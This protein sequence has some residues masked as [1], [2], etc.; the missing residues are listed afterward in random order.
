[1]T[2]HTRSNGVL[3]EDENAPD[4]YCLQLLR[5]FDAISPTYF[6]NYVDSLLLKPDSDTALSNALGAVSWLGT[7]SGLS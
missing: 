5:G 3:N 6:Y 1:M 4:P 2:F 7:S